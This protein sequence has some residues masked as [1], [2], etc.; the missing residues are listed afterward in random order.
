MENALRDGLR[1]LDLGLREARAENATMTSLFAIEESVIALVQGGGA[2]AI[3]L[4][5]SLLFRSTT[6]PSLLE[7]IRVSQQEQR[8]QGDVAV[9]KAR[10]LA[11]DIINDFTSCAGVRNLRE[12]APQI[13]TRCFDT[14][15]R[16]YDGEAKVMALR[17]LLLLC[18]VEAA[19]ASST[20]EHGGLFAGRANRSGEEDALHR[21]AAAMHGVS[22][23]TI[24]SE[25]TND[26]KTNKTGKK[27]SSSS[28]KEMLLSV[29]GVLLRFHSNAVGKTLVQEIAR[30]AADRLF[31]ETKHVTWKG[32][33]FIAGALR[34]LDGALSSQWGREQLLASPI[35]VD[36]L[37]LRAKLYETIFVRAAVRQG[38]LYVTVSAALALIARHAPLFDAELG[39]EPERAAGKGGHLAVIARLTDGEGAAAHANK[40]DVR[41]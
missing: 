39:A 3:A 37:K 13:I 22:A 34:C 2:G 28:V 19:A 17:P 9:A 14:A 29:L 41:R 32:Q 40:S 8:L 15:R 11:F 21:A 18:R 23:R 26:F 31:K 20:S 25:L 16:E 33:K 5:A 1:N 7:W 30:I 36:G 12:H 35:Q 10:A 4:A 38:H 27:T 6:P 24:A